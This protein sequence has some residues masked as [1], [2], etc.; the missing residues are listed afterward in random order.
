[1]LSGH[2]SS[3]DEPRQDCEAT[4]RTAANVNAV[5]VVMADASLVPPTFSG[6]SGSDA[7]AWVRRFN[8]Y[9]DFRRLDGDDRLPLFRVLLVD[10]AA[11]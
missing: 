3:R 8:N 6:A 10:A 2:L 7:D 5:T 9:C 11:D 4:G 1:M